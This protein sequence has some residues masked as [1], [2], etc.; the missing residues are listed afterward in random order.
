[1]RF[2]WDIP[3]K[4]TLCPK[5]PSK[6][7]PSKIT[8]KFDRFWTH[9][10]AHFGTPENVLFRCWFFKNLHIS[11]DILQKSRSGQLV[12]FLKKFTFFHENRALA[13]MAAQFH[14]IQVFWKTH[15]CLIFFLRICFS[16]TREANIRALSKLRKTMC[17]FSPFFEIPIFPLFFDGFLSRES[18]NTS[19]L[20]PRRRSP[21]PSEQF[22]ALGL[23]QGLPKGS[24]EPPNGT[25][26]GAKM[27]PKWVQNR[28]PRVKNRFQACAKFEK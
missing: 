2:A 21:T 4:L 12:R 25:K 11:W 16:P 20:Q 19:I 23:S 18:K 14:E 15:F 7:R 6:K 1:M 17:F 9:F 8:S 28:T 13:C 27:D 26:I 3:R 10:G 5:M 24:P 22:C